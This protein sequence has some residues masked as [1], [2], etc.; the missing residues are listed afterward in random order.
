[1]TPK[2]WVHNHETNAEWRMQF[3]WPFK[4]A[5]LIVYLDDDYQRTIIGVPDRSYVWIMSRDPELNDAEYQ[6]LLGEV[7]RLGYDSAKVQRIPQRWP[8]E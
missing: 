7:T 8:A 2:G 3:L 6:G 1:M 5:Y 4:A